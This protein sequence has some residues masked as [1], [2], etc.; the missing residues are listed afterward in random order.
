MMDGSKRS[1]ALGLSLSLISMLVA[2]VLL[3]L[4]AGAAQADPPEDFAVWDFEAASTAPSL[5][6][7]GNAE[8]ASGPGLTLEA[9]PGGYGSTHSWGFA[10]WSTGDLDPDDYF[11]FKVDLGKYGGITLSFAEKRSIDGVRDFE[12]R[13]STNGTVFTPISATVTHLDD[14]A[15]W[16][17]HSF[18][19]ASGDAVDQAIRGKH[20]VYFRIYGSHADESDDNDTWRID[21]VTFHAGEAAALSIAKTARDN[22]VPGEVF[23]YTVY[24]RNTTGVSLTGTIVTDTLPANVT[25]VPDSASHEGQLIDGKVVSWTISGNFTSGLT[26]SR[27]FQVTASAGVGEELVNDGYAVVASNWTTPVVGAAV[28][29]TIVGVDLQIEKGVQISREPVFPGD[30]LTYTIVVANSGP[31]DATGA[32]VTD[33]L[34][35]GVAGVGLSWTGVVT[36]GQEVTFVIPAVVTTSSAFLGETVVNTASY[37][38]DGVRGSD[39]AQFTIL[40]AWHTYLPVILRNH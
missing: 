30:P 17:V 18:N 4:M 14:N 40:D 19:F 2:M 39:N 22:V 20:A 25:Y 28:T 23:T 11:Q 10:G 1:P 8:A 37:S 16:N 38:Y 31:S 7:T 13:Y 35:A 36:G 32:V 26:I 3:F 15:G 9:F 33:V 24:V 34:P 6:L 5:D 29:T 21:D 27:T 12:V